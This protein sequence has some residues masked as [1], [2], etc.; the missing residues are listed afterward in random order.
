MIHTVSTRRNA[1]QEARYEVAERLAKILI[2]LVESSGQ[3]AAGA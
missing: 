3:G 2:M 1:T